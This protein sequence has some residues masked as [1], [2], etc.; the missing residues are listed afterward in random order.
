MKHYLSM[1]MMVALV[2]STYTVAQEDLSDVFEEVDLETSEEVA[3]TEEE[4]IVEEDDDDDKVVIEEDE[5]LLEDDSND[6]QN[7]A[8]TLDGGKKKKS[9]LDSLPEVNEEESKEISRLF[10][11]A[12]DNYNDILDNRPEAEMRTNL[13]R[14]KANKGLVK[15]NQDKLA[16][17]QSDLRRM[18]LQYIK[19]FLVLKN[20]YKRGKFPKKIYDAELAKLAKSYEFKVREL[21]DDKDFYKGELK[22]TKSR[23][24]ALDE[25][26]RINKIMHPKR[27]TKKQRKSK[28]KKPLT[29]LEKM[30][31]KVQSTSDWFDVK[32]VWDSPDRN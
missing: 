29:E 31:K 3:N 32:D 4:V 7:F 12:A 11:K 27:T 1:F 10:K 22:Q 8:D 25:L 13:E 23:V 18:K 30:M 26:N 2:F 28:K 5:I 16:T 6:I 17:S 24:K 20:S 15:S 19:R 14:L 21:A 9:L